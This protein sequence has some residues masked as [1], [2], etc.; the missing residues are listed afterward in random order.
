MV[1]RQCMSVICLLVFGPGSGATEKKVV[2]DGQ[3]EQLDARDG[4]SPLEFI[5]QAPPHHPKGVLFILHGCSHS[6]TD[7]WPWSETRCPSCRGLPIEGTIVA[8]ALERGWVVAAVSSENRAHKCWGPRDPPRLKVVLDRIVSKTGAPM[9][10]A[11]IGASSG[12]A[13]SARL[14]SADTEL[15]GL[16]G[17]VAQI[18]P[19]SQPALLEKPIRFVHMRRDTRR[20]AVINK[21]VAQLKA[22]H[23]D[24]EEF[25]VEPKPLTLE[26]FLDRPQPVLDENTARA[27]L[28]AFERDGIIDTKGNILEDPRASD[29]RVSAAAVIPKQVD[30]LQP[31]V[32]PVSELMNSHWAY[33]EFTDAFLDTCLDWLDHKLLMSRN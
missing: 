28:Q 30:N 20:A 5:F 29:W 18:M 16:V 12:G 15:P 19:A 1:A 9:R 27:L 2:L 25:V 3:Y 8:H 23:F 14:A 10:T 24:A 31:D 22:R 7:A 17:T 13:M 26:A 4:G 32:S 6:A 33:H 11:T 21:Q